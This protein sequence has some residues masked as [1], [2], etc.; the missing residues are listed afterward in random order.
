MFKDIKMIYK[1]IYFKILKEPMII[2]FSF[3]ILIIILTIIF[4]I[5]EIKNDK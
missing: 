3:V 5:K 2:L 1:P 4:V